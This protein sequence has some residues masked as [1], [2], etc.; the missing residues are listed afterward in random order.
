ML[1]L[2]GADL[3]GFE[4]IPAGVYDA[5]IFKAEMGETKGGPEA[6][7]PAGTPRLNV[8]FRIVDG[9]EGS[10]VYNRRVFTSFNFPDESYDA[11]KRAK[12][13]GFFVRFMVAIGY[14]QKKLTN[15]KFQLD[16][17]DLGGRECRVVVAQKPKYG[18][19]EGEMDNEVKGVKERGEGSGSGSG[20][21]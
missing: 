4:P 18:G 2:S 21:L 15:G 13:Q 11:A 6:K 12:A 10:P 8:Q 3:K 7:L 1:D 5:E 20:L 16:V 9:G 19:V 14:D 17:E